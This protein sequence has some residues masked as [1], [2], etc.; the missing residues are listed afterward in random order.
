MESRRS[1]SR[2]LLL[3][4]IGFS[5]AVTL[6]AKILG[7]NAAE[8]EEL[9]RDDFHYFDDNL[10]NLHFYFKNADFTSASGRIYKTDPKKKAYMIVRIP[11]QHLTEELIRESEFAARNQ[12]GAAPAVK[13]SGFS[14]LA[15]E[16][17]P[18]IVDPDSHLVINKE[19]LLDLGN[20]ARYKLLSPS[21][22]NYIPFEHKLWIPFRAAT[23]RELSDAVLSPSPTYY[24]N[25]YIEACKKLF[26][27]DKTNAAFPLTL[28]EIPEGMLLTPFAA[29]NSQPV[30]QTYKPS[31]KR[32]IYESKNGTVNRVVEEIWNTQMFFKQNE[33]LIEPSLRAVGYYN[34][35]EELGTRPNSECPTETSNFLPTLIDK[36][37]LVFL[38]SLG[39][40]YNSGKEWNIETKGLVLTGLGAIS[41][42]HY[43]NFTPPVN[44]DLAEY[45]HHI[46]LGRDE[47]IK[48]ARIGVISVTG[49][50]ALHV[51]IGQRKIV[52]GT[53]Y[54]QFK[55]YVEII[56]K[57]LLYF[58]PALFNQHENRPQEPQNYIHARIASPDATNP[59]PTIAHTS[60]SVNSETDNVWY[61]NLVW[62]LRTTAGRYIP[63]EPTTDPRKKWYTHYRRWPFK[64]VKSVTHITAPIDTRPDP[65]NSDKIIPCS[66]CAADSPMAFWPVLEKRLATDPYR[67]ATLLFQGI[68]WNDKQ[69]DFESTFIFI[70]KTVIDGFETNCYRDIYANF[71]RQRR[72]RTHIFTRLKDIAFTR[73][74]TPS[75]ENEGQLPNRSNSSNTEYLEYYF[76]FCAEPSAIT[77]PR[78][79]SVFNERFFPL[80]PQI[81]KAS[82][83]IENI[84][85]Y[86]PEPLPSIIEYN[87]DYVTAGFESEAT[88]AIVQAGATNIIQVTPYNKARLIF[89][90]TEEFLASEG[91][92]NIRNAFANAGPAIGGLVN[93]DFDLQT[94]GLI[95]QGLAVGKDINRKMVAINSTAETI[96]NFSP[97]DLFRQVP[98][99][100]NGISLLDILLPE[101]PSIQAPVNEIK[102]VFA[103]IDE[104]K[105]VVLK[106]PIYIELQSDISAVNKKIEDF[107]AEIQN[108]NTEISRAVAEVQLLKDK[109][110][111][112]YL[113]EEVNHLTINATLQHKITILSSVN[114]IIELASDSSVIDYLATDL[115]SNAEYFKEFFNDIKKSLN[116]IAKIRLET[117]GR[118]SA[119]TLSRINSFSTKYLSEAATLVF[120]HTQSDI[121]NALKTLADVKTNIGT[122]VSDLLLK[123]NNVTTA[124]K[125][126]FTIQTNYNNTPTQILFNQLVA[127]KSITLTARNLYKL[128]LQAHIDRRIVPTDLI[129]HFCENNQSDNIILSAYSFE[130]KG[131]VSAVQKVND[132]F[133]NVDLATVINAYEK[134][135]EIYN[136]SKSKLKISI[137]GEAVGKIINT[138]ES[139][140][141]GSIKDKITTKRDELLNFYNTNYN[142]LRA[143][144]A[145]LTKGA[146]NLLFEYSN[147][148][149]TIPLAS[150]NS[151]LPDEVRQLIKLIS[152]QEDKIKEWAKSLNEQKTK[153]EK[154]LLSQASGYANSLSD[155]FRSK[156]EEYRRK[157][158]SDPENIE[159]RNKV[160]KSLELLNFINSFSKQDL[161][162]RWQTTSFKP[163]DFG[164][165]SFQPNSSP[166]TALKVDVN[167]TINFQPGV[168]PPVIKNIEYR[169]ENRLTNFGIGLMKAITI[170]FNEVSFV[171]ATNQSVKFDVQIRDVQFAGAFSFVQA[172]ESWLR[173]LLGNAFRINLQPTGVNIGYTLPIPDIKTPS[174]NFFNLTLNFDFWL[175]FI[176]KPMLL[177]FSFATKDNK[178]GISVGIF[179]GFGFFSIQAEPKK[180]ITNLEVGLEFGGY[181]GLSLGPLRGE[182]KLVVGLYYKKDSTGV[183]IEGYFLCEGRVKLWFIMI[184]ARF[185]MG[186]RSQGGYV[187]GRCTATF[188]VSLGAFFKLSFTATYYKKIAGSSPGNNQSPAFIAAIQK[189]ALSHARTSRPGD[190]L[191][192]NTYEQKLATVKNPIKRTAIPLSNKQWE[193][194]LETYID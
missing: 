54:M 194:F 164:I 3:G 122:L 44:S 90:H 5:P 92:S 175:S 70:R 75:E 57:D 1:F 53:S 176:R 113:L 34:R 28:L 31:K 120:S 192:E 147:S 104:T 95:K 112:K 49:Q 73:N 97:S 47:Y 24:I 137:L 151:L 143:D 76:S 110:S 117:T 141:P 169:A 71:T 142:L 87:L 64:A 139:E 106:N 185:Y 134:A 172:F 193:A 125:S 60:D 107:I 153:Y 69:I 181:F 80:F 123:Y 148:I 50:K 7:I 79:R 144:H 167:T 25:S 150:I 133:R 115:L 98:E 58:N 130:L 190:V 85:S 83:L 108:L 182:V 38:S 45:E 29:E 101:F 171:V 30:I 111:T 178:F 32:F 6:L 155:K 43:K 179:A 91:Y 160:A 18:G 77:F 146:R 78:T 163:A 89:N 140:G 162:Y 136:T 189:R 66:T 119:S 82:I 39:R 23:I 42:F 41:K 56:Q 72:E 84:Q 27:A 105:D 187:E 11:Q 67:D 51:K 121:N 14:Y 177:G 173:T 152:T 13:I 118:L 16:F 88:V 188:E 124:L 2:K 52:N 132:S 93:P 9:L 161:T 126:E 10:T 170:N 165:V 59:A 99:I 94:I 55:E 138:L 19:T 131:I 114:G 159:L 62:D 127:A 128:E 33:L 37:E 184:T 12:A 166:T 4:T 86:S 81:K 17:L 156:A 135:N 157:L 8:L 103:V 100:F 61:D 35:N 96:E 180:G 20:T 168:F 186:V 21:E 116:V 109:L 149:T 102:K 129:T 36:K 65:L 40:G 154:L 26:Q 68:D 158:L 183:L 174:F 63:G 22:N 48:V 74:Y 46:T 145:Q 15:F 191:S